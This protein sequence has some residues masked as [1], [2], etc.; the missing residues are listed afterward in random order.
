[1]TIILFEGTFVDTITTLSPTKH[2]IIHA[3]KAI[4]KGISPEANRRIPPL[5]YEYVFALIRDFP[6]L[7]FTINGGIIAV[8]QVEAALK[9]GAFGVMVGRA[10]YNKFTSTSSILI[11]GSMADSAPVLGTTRDAPRPDTWTYELTEQDETD[12]R[13]AIDHFS[14]RTLV[15]R[16]VGTTPSRPTVR[17]WIELALGGS[18]AC[19]DQ[20]IQRSEF[21]CFAAVWMSDALGIV[22]NCQNSILE[23]FRAPNSPWS[24][25]AKV[26]SE[27]YGV[28]GISTTRREILS[29]YA[30]YADSILGKYGPG[31]PSIRHTVKPLLHLF[32]AE[33]GA[34]LWRRAVDV[35]LRDSMSCSELLKRTLAVLPEDVLDSPPPPA[36]S[37]GENP[38]VVAPEWPDVPLFLQSVNKQESGASY[39]PLLDL[40][41]CA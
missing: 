36:R 19:P 26:D 35:A 29:A 17:E 33:Q 39:E 27:F 31:K 11:F 28:Q 15:G 23:W 2:F 40:V 12:M 14:G 25:L 10:S 3:R 13:M 20:K 21:Y 41:L 38:L 37:R 24:L 30:E 22:P 32:H 18:T 6:H 34:G 5:K 9:M 8:G 16:L 7:K 1:M 4:L